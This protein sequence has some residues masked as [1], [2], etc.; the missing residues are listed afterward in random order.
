M[1]LSARRPASVPSTLHWRS[2]RTTIHASI[3]RWL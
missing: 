1:I 2:W 3:H